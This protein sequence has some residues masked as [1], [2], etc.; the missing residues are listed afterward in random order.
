MT[1]DPYLLSSAA[2]MGVVAYHHAIYPA[3]MAGLGQKKTKSPVFV[4]DID[5][6][7]LAIIMPAFNEAD[8]ILSKLR[9]IAQSDYPLSKIEVFVGCDGCTDKTAMLARWAGEKYEGLVVRV[10]EFEHNRGKVRV[11]NDLLK[12]SRQEISVLTDVSASL[13]PSALRKIASHF[14]NPRVGAVGGGYE[15]PQQSGTG[16]RAYSLYQKA[17]KVGESRIAGLVG[18][19]GSLYAI[20]TDLFD[21]LPADTVNDDFFI[22][23]SIA[24]RKWQTVYDPEIRVVERDL[25]NDEDDGRRRRRIG[26][27]NLQQAVRLLPTVL[28]SGEAGL[29]FAFVSG[30]TLRTLMGPLICLSAALLLVSAVSGS[31]IAAGLIGL[32]L[33]ASATRIGRYA[34]NGH[35]Q[36]MFGMFEYIRGQHRQWKRIS[37]ASAETP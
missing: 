5:L 16:Q 3:L 33:A 30:K 36:S 18:A 12:M 24:A 19:H 6:P 29:L 35:L 31:F 15:L 10:L 9:S 4:S 32:G 8:H 25:T 13:I 28:R 34:L 37:I 23:M 17:I 2:C 11:L 22:P 14:A 7:T 1:I 21:P 26:A 27:G 20:R